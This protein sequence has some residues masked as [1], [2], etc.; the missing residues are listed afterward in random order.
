[1]YLPALKNAIQHVEEKVFYQ[2]AL[3]YL[4]TLG[5][6]DV[7]IV[8]GTG[9]GGRD[10][11]CSRD[12]LRIQLSVRKDWGK[13][14]NE[15]AQNTLDS[16]CRHLIYVTNKIIS[17]SAEQEFLQGK[18][19]HK[20]DIDVSIHDL[21]RV[22]TALAQPGVIRR[23]YEM[24]GMAV[25]SKLDASPKEIA[26]STVLLFSDEARELRD[27]VID[28]N[29]RAQ[30]L[31]EPGI[32][33]AVVVQRVADAV[34]GVNID[35]TAKSALAR[36]RSSGRI[37]GQNDSLHLS[38]EERT[39]ME[40]AA[41]EFMVAINADI[42]TLSNVSGLQPE[43]ARKLL[44]IALELLVRNRD[45][46]GTGP[47]EESLRNFLAKHNLTRKRDTIF[48]ALAR[49]S[50]ATFTEHGA[51]IDRMFSLNSF[52]IYR[53]L[54][55]RTDV[56]IV[57]DSSVAMPVIFGLEF[58]AAKSRYGIAALALREACKA[59][60][61]QMVV[62]RCYIN[63]MAAH[64]Q[65]ALEKLEIYSKLP[66][67][68]RISLRASGN[69][70]LSHYTHIRETMRESGDDLS[71]DEFLQH[72]GI[73]MGRPIG[74]IENR[75]ES[76]L[77][78]HDIACLPD[79]RYDPL[80]FQRIAEKKPSEFRLLVEHDAIVCTLLK[81]DDQRGFILATWD[82]I[83]MDVV[84]SVARVLA[85]TPAR[86]IDFLSMAGGQAF[87]CEQNFE[88]LTTLLHTDEKAAQKL[89]EKIDRI[90]SVEQAY[91]LSAFVEEAR[92]QKGGSFVLRPEDIVPFLDH[93]TPQIENDSEA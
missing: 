86:I 63:E 45:L 51:T 58:G 87:E 36:L 13:K 46:N 8:D 64:G 35:R 23:A 72:F 24:L 16:N 31:R 3:M 22:S 62:P 91:K 83:L 61:I 84:E 1:M 71:L 6:Q 38:Q 68:A 12:D 89:A 66:E 90:E 33:H 82:K 26:L 5:Y 19:E 73:V 34:P 2:V 43:D 17:P 75:I 11:T 44:D 47:I 81:N 41:T 92:S 53:A 21:R 54:G 15:E 25:P 30:I 88:L 29:I 76:L 52:D 60:N 85:D 59:H 37:I 40:A 55:R 4:M 49:T 39:T 77:E 79:G 74:R 69:A 32:S 20:G 78:Q 50:S 14:I 7:S 42:A 10:V 67:E 56:S 57:L 9:D 18:Y 80:V 65:G 28:A 70:Y 27:S 48:Q 93:E